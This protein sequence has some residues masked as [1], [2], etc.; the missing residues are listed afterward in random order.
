MPE[1]PAPNADQDKTDAPP[2]GQQPATGQQPEAGDEPLGDG[3]KK[4][5][6]AEREARKTAEKDLA[7]LRGEFDT[8]KTS[9]AGA[10]G[11][12]PD[13]ASAEDAVAQLQ[14]RLDTMQRDT[15]VYRLAAHHQITEQADIDLLR[16]ATDAEAMGKLAERL[17]A[18]GSDG[19]PGTPRPDA[20]QGGSGTGTSSAG[21]P[22]QDFAK[23]LGQQLAG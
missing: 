22:E 20:T 9:L 21:T 4:A 1:A 15:D 12:K 17:A 8:L 2:T 3:G 14:Q 18:K 6:E 5:L 10:L 13:G 7:A 19:T 23:F 11:V 16:S